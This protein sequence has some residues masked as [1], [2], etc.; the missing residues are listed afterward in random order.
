MKA[1]TLL[2]LPL[3]CGCSTSLAPERQRTPLD[4]PAGG[5]QRIEAPRLRP[6]P[7][8]V[9][10][11]SKELL[12]PLRRPGGI[13]GRILN[14]AVTGDLL[15]SRACRGHRWGKRPPL[16]RPKWQRYDWAA[17]IRLLPEARSQVS[18]FVYEYP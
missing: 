2:P 17:E 3:I 9:A 16:R 12:K 15:R 13:V 4:S 7:E 8:S 18:I 14:V 11:I 5:L 6:D 1:P 10:S